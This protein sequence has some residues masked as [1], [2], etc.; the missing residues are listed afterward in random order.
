M[1]TRELKGLH[2]AATAQIQQQGDTWIVPSER[3]SKKY[4]VRFTPSHQTCTCPDYEARQKMCKHIFAVERI[5]DPQQVIVTPDPLKRPTYKQEWHEYNLAQTNEKARFMEF[6]YEL[7]RGVEEPAQQRWGR[8]RLSF[9]EMIFSTC[10]KVYS[11]Q[12]SRRFISDLR[13]ATLKGYISKTPHFNS[14]SNYLEM[15]EMTPYLKDLIRESSR[16]LAAVEKDFAVDSSGFTTGRFVRWMQAKYTDPH[17]IE[18][19]DWVKV[20]LM[21]GVKTNIVTSVEVTGAHAG[22]SPYFKPLVEATSEN[23]VMQE[24]SADK[25]YSSSDNLKLVLDKGAMPYI[26]FRSNATGT[27]KRSSAVWKRMYHFYQYNQEWF[28]AHYHKRSNVET[29]FSMIKAKFGERLRGKAETAQVNEVLCKILCHNLC[30][31]I[32]SIYELGI[33]PTFWESR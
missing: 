28:F 3:T 10:F 11:T 30:C 18:K 29:T 17:L 27:D 9:A 26:A 13:A 31:L 6:L 1:H 8:P 19:Q 23:F 20:H 16:P 15:K 33:E 25:A 7:C 12:S 32:Q 22:D 21:A 24:V 5:L 2:L 14:L 4:T